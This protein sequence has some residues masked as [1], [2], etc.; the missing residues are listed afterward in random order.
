MRGKC[1][2]GVARM[3]LRKLEER[4]LRKTNG[5]LKVDSRRTEKRL[6]ENRDKPE[7]R[8]REK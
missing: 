5:V 2:S 1:A 6:S 7:K 4:R 3:T 8:Q